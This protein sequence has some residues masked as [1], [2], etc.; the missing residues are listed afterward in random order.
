MEKQNLDTNKYIIESSKSIKDYILIV[1]NNLK[2]FIIIS[3]AILSLAVI[4]ALYA[5]NIYKSSVSLKINLPQQNVLMPV[6][7]ESGINL[8]DRFIA[9]EIGIINK[10]DT[11]EKVAK[12]LID[13]FNV[14]ID[15]TRFSVIKSNDPNVI[16]GHK[17]LEDLSMALKNIVSAEQTTGTD[18]IEIS[19][20][21]PSP[22]EAALI[23]RTYAVQ[24]S[25]LNLEINRKQLSIIRNF[26]EKQS[27]EKLAELNLAEDT[28]K[29]FKQKG[30]I[31]KLD[32]QTTDL[33]SQL[34]GLDA[35]RDATKIDLMTSNE[36]LQQYK[37]KLKDQD[38]R[39]AEYLDSQT[40]Q[41]YIDVIQKQIAELQM[42]RDLA[43]ANKNPNIDVTAK[44][45]NYN[46]KINELKENLNTK[47]ADIKASSYSNSPDQAK[48]LTNKFI[49][50]EIRNRSLNIKLTQLQSLINTYENKLNKMPG[51]TIELARYERKK[52]SLEQLFGLVDKRYQEAALNELSQP[53]NALIIDRARVPNK[54]TKP[55]R[56]LIV[57]LG[58]M[59]GLGFAYG[60]V[61]IK[62]YF[63]DKI[64]SPAD[65]QNENIDVLAWIPHLDNIGKKNSEADKFIIAENPE[66]SANEAF[67]AIKARIQ[68]SKIDSETPKIILVTSPAEQEGKTLVAINLA[69]NAA[70]SNEKTLLIDCDLRRPRIHSIMNDNKKPGLVDYL[71]KKVCLDEIIK[72]SSINNFSYIAAGTY[73]FYPAQILASNAMK[74]FLDEMRN[75]FDNIIIDSAPIVAVIDS[76]ILSKIVDGTLLVVSAEKTEINLMLE[77]VKLL[78]KNNDNTFLGTVLNNFKYKNGY[79][80]YYKYY[81]NYHSNGK[82]FKKHKGKYEVLKL[83]FSY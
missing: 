26:L 46:Q 31:V 81:Y 79:G 74:Y 18:E 54:P 59:A 4:Y 47:F 73:P 12:A 25:N 41:A 34:A 61:I 58:L 62:E 83:M 1:R 35:E 20:E 65:I 43:M 36:V 78:K 38:P 19:A 45:N 24:Y 7:N 2:P 28:L 76:E 48:E 77:A 53:G 82:D 6:S 14:S 69:I 29:Y 50:E 27:K 67:S 10:Y 66:L 15:K 9:N 21:S 11:R 3:V 75:T 80:Y 8:L 23:A 44:I 13:S 70:K 51:T 39:L 55:N 60:Y 42:N 57:V 33:I 52:E 64:Q 72:D 49:D 68:F 63:N 40:S 17:N 5:K 56:I 32:E 37:I 71:F 22:F 30:G 16:N